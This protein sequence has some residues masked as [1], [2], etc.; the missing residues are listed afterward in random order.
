MTLRC[1]AGPRILSHVRHHSTQT[2]RLHRIHQRRHRTLR[3]RRPAFRASSRH[4][5]RQIIPAR[6]T[7]N[8]ALIERQLELV[9]DP[10]HLRLRPPVAPTLAFA[11]HKQQHKCDVG[12]YQ[13]KVSF[14]GIYKAAR[15]VSLLI[16]YSKSTQQLSR[17]ST[18][19]RISKKE[20]YPPPE[21]KQEIEGE[22]GAWSKGIFQEQGNIRS[23]QGKHEKQQENVVD[24]PVNQIGKFAPTRKAVPA[25]PT[26][27]EVIQPLGFPPQKP[28]RQLH[29]RPANR[30]RPNGCGSIYQA[31]TSI[32]RPQSSSESYG[33]PGSQ[34]VAA[35]WRSL[36]LRSLK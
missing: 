3:H 6:Q 4:V 5:S 30:T 14:D 17:P 12:H 35:M 36:P 24:H 19:E 16:D 31:N 9:L 28:S 32:P 15:L 8:P 1:S 18:I 22:N 2:L 27:A 33:E 13:W 20:Q 26:N 23:L 10:N 7:P 34:M 25:F 29:V 11:N 21:K